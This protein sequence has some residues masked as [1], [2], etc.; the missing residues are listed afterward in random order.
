MVI[1]KQNLI[2]RQIFPHI[3]EHL[4][5][6]E[7]TVIIGPRQVGKTTL[8]EQ[9]K[10]YLINQ[11][12][13][14]PDL[15]FYFNLDLT[16]DLSLFQKQESVIDFIKNRNL[17]NQIM[18]LFIDEVQRIKNAG[19]FLKGIYDSKLKVKFILTGS[20]SINGTANLGW[21]KLLN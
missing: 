1:K 2:R 10:D 5:E 9:I 16:K 4:P 18:Y 21:I 3:I 11:R 19:K 17:D 15:L 8:L 13:V 20:S 6:E 14:N 12:K 7:M